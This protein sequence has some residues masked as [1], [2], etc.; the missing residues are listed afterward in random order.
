L[1]KNLFFFVKVESNLFL[2]LHFVRKFFENIFCLHFATSGRIWKNFCASAKQFKK[3]ELEFKI[4]TI[5]LAV[6]DY[7][8]PKSSC[9]RNIKQVNFYCF[10]FLLINY[11]LYGG[12]LKK[13]RLVGEFII[14]ARNSN[15]LFFSVYLLFIIF[16]IIYCLLFTIDF[17]LST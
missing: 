4:S 11:L 16:D 6:K 2:R 7:M 10:F 17:I 3:F 8:P 9:Q 12:M 5:L 1:K 13:I 14:S 15:N